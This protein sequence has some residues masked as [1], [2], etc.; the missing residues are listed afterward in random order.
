MVLEDVPPEIDHEVSEAQEVRIEV[1]PSPPTWEE[2]NCELLKV[3]LRSG[4]EYAIDLSAAQY[5]YFNTP[6]IEWRE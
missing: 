5:G 2:M 6:V 3:R 4:E 1:E